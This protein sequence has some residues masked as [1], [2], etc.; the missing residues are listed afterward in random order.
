MSRPTELY[1]Q[2]LLDVDDIPAENRYLEIAKNL[3]CYG[4]TVADDRRPEEIVARHKTISGINCDFCSATGS[5]NITTFDP[6][7]SPKPSL[8]FSVLLEGDQSIRGMKKSAHAR[9]SQGTLNVHQRNDYYTYESNDVNQVYLIPDIEIVNGIFNGRL[10][11]PTVSL[12]NH[13]LM[14]FM[15]SHMLLLHQQG[16]LLNVKQASVILDGLHNMAMLMLTDVAKEKGLISSG[17]LSH[18]Y[19]AA[20][21]WI[22]QN[23]HLQ[24]LNPDQISTVLCYSRSSL[25]RAFKEQGTTV[26]AT[27]KDLRLTK[28]KALLEN[29][30]HLRIDRV[31]WECG[32]SNQFIFSKNFREKYHMPP[33]VWRDNFGGT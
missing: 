18:I 31:A 25:D 16:A 11:N 19:N 3:E 30:P 5:R 2:H 22:E 15:K 29:H 9:V 1:V 14:P 17:A 13:P 4:I 12:E 23:Y 7:K 21:S 24:A 27:I 10:T 26:M 6:L 8:Y 32:F 20:R 28:A 33:K